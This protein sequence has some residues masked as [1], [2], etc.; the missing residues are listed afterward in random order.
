[1][2]LDSPTITLGASNLELLCDVKILSFLVCFV[3]MLEI[4]NV[5]VKFAQL[6]D[7]FNL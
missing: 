4:V 7:I 1:M 5:L 6:H 3:P 2:A